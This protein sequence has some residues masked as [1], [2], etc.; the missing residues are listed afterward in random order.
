MFQPAS[1]P[2]WVLTFEWD[3]GFSRNSTTVAGILGCSTAACTGGALVPFNLSGNSTTVKFG[4]TLSPPRVGY[5]VLPNVQAYVTGGVAVQ[6]ISATETCNGATSPACFLGVLTSTSSTWLTG[7]SMG[8]G[9]EWQVLPHW[10]LRAEY[11]Y[12]N[13]GNWKTTS[14][15]AAAKS[16]LSTPC[17]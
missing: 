17:T 9:L 15:W 10:L 14:S 16:R 2:N 12:N 6:K 11:R 1:A 7:Y 3:Y 13:Y 5:L 4:I 8:G